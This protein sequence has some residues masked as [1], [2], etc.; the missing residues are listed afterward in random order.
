MRIQIDND[1]LYSHLDRIK[2]KLD[3]R[4]KAPYDAEQ[5]QIPTSQGILVPTPFCIIA[6]TFGLTPDAKYTGTIL[7]RGEGSFMPPQDE[8]SA[9]ELASHQRIYEATFEQLARIYKSRWQNVGQTAG[10]ISLDNEP[11][12]FLSLK[13]HSISASIGAPG[14][15]PRAL[16]GTND[17][18]DDCFYL[19][20]VVNTVANTTL[21]IANTNTTE[22]VH[23]RAGKTQ[24]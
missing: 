24:L 17:F 10:Y 7:F 22:H 15:I 21:N 23:L 3:T 6:G 16:N 11:L 20:T 1:G 19:E 2:H 4:R 5:M 14:C 9:A 8:K 18:R 13:N 12:M